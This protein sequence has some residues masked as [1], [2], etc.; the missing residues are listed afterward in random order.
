MAWLSRY[1]CLTHIVFLLYQFLVMCSKLIQA[2]TVCE[3]CFTSGIYLIFIHQH[4][5]VAF[6]NLKHGLGS[7]VCTIFTNHFVQNYG[8]TDGA[9]MRPCSAYAAETWSLAATVF[10]VQ[11]FR[12]DTGCKTWP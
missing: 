6:L 9:S 8:R 11:E 4:R 1:L 3:R 10:A 7:F 2:L 12:V 5:V